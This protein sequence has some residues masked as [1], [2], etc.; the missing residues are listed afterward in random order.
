[1]LAFSGKE[2]LKRK[3]EIMGHPGDQ[4]R[5]YLGDSEKAVKLL[6]VP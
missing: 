6:D 3:I 1:V 5:A 2:R 4:I